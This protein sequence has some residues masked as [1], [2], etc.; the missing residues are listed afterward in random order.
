MKMQR[1]SWIILY[2]VKASRS[3]EVEGWLAIFTDAAAAVSLDGETDRK[4]TSFHFRETPRRQG[5]GICRIVCLSGARIVVG[6]CRGH[7][8]PRM[9][10]DLMPRLGVPVHFPDSDSRHVSIKMRG[11]YI[12]RKQ[13][14]FCWQSLQCDAACRS[15]L[16]QNGRRA[17]EVKQKDSVV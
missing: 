9:L 12:S 16:V 8:P 13:C 7:L 15:Q 3:T 10:C 4:L 11:W 17:A 5:Q 1:S 14:A 2:F 6:G